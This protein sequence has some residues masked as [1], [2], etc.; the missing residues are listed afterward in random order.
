MSAAITYQP[1]DAEYPQRSTYQSQYIEYVNEYFKKANSTMDASTWK[2]VSRSLQLR[3]L[4]IAIN[5]NV[6]HGFLSACY[7]GYEQ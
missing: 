7:F 5:G 1:A 3:V 6:K 4:Q 2:C